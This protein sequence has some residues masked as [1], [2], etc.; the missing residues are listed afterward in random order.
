MQGKGQRFLAKGKRAFLFLRPL[1]L[2][3]LN[4]GKLV[5]AIISGSSF[6]WVDCFYGFF[7]NVARFLIFKGEKKDQNEKVRI[8]LA[9]ALL[10]FFSALSYGTYNIIYFFLGTPKS[11][12]TI[13]AIAIA[14]FAFIQLGINIYSLYKNRQ[15]HDPFQRANNYLS[16]SSLAT[17][18]VLTQFALLSLKDENQHNIGNGL[19]VIFA[20]LLM[21][22]FAILLLFKYRKEKLKLNRDKIN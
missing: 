1:V 4:I 8:L 10:L 11:Y 16:C 21:I 13:Y 7:L 19:I 9:V 6:L 3:A 15:N 22:T 5:L 17:V 12:G 18:F 20:S 14:T 2:I